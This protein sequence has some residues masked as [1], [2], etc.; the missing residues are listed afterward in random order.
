MILK[1]KKK[2]LFILPFVSVVEEKVNYFKEI[3]KPLDWNVCGFFANRGNP[4]FEEV[5]IAVCTIEKAN[6]LVNRL[7][8]ETRLE[9]VGIIVIDE[10]HMMGDEDR[11]YLLEL[12]VTKILYKNLDHLQV[13][14]Q[15]FHFSF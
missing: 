1:M 2:A 8:E 10:V 14:Q 5:D 4:H 6:G 7:L 15:L 11:G 13:I 9:E 12:L 3:F